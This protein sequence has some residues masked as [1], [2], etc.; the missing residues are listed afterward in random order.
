MRTTCRPA[1]ALVA[2]EWW[3]PDYDGPPLVSFEKK[4][5]DGLGLKL[6]DPITVNVLGRNITARI[7]N[8]RAVDWESLGINFVHGVLAQR[9]RAARRIRISRR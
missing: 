6:G 4:I 9:F 1:R 3:Q 8:L 7:A 2:G 5:A